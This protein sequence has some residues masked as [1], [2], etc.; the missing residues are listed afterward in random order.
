MRQQLFRAKAH[1]LVLILQHWR[2]LKA[3]SV[4]HCDEAA[5]IQLQA[6]AGVD[7]SGECSS[8][9]T[10]AIN[11][12]QCNF[13][14]A[15]TSCEPSLGQ[16][17]PFA[18]DETGFPNG[19]L[20]CSG[21][22][23]C[24]VADPVSRAFYN[25]K[26][27]NDYISC[28]GTQACRDWR[29]RNLA[30]ACCLDGD[31]NCERAEFSL[32]EGNPS[33]S[34]DIC[35]KGSNVCS[36][37]RI[38][39]ASS[40]SCRGSSVCFR[41]QMNTLKKDLF[42]EGEPT[43]TA[44]SQAVAVFGGGS[45]SHCIRCL[46]NGNATCSSSLFSWE[47]SATACMRCE[48]QACDSAQLLLQNGVNLY[49]HCGAGSCNNL[50]I[51]SIS[52][53]S[54]S[55]SGPGCSDINTTVVN[56]VSCPVVDE[57]LQP[58][59]S[60]PATGEA[61]AFCDRGR[62]AEPDCSA[63]HQGGGFGQCNSVDTEAIN[64]GQ[65]NFDG[66]CTSCEPS[67]G[68]PIPFASDETGFPNGVLNCSGN[69]V[70]QVADPVSRAFYNFKNPNDYISCAGTQACRDWRVRNLAAACCLDGDLN[71]ERA[72]FSL[73]EGNPSC[74][75]DICCKGSNVCSR[76][77][78][79]SASSVSCRG[80]SVCFRAQMNT[81]KKDLFCEGEP[82]GTACSQA[83]AVFG[84][85]SGSHCIRCLGNGNATCS[86]SR[87]SW[88]PSATACMRCETQACDSAQLL[89]QN[90]VN[91][92]LHC[93]AGSCNN[94]RIQS[95]STV[96]CSCSG[97]GCSDINTTV[98]NSVSCPVVDEALQP[99]S[100]CPATGE[101]TAFCDRGRNAEPDC[102]ACHQGGG[103]VTGDPHITALDGR[104][105]TLL[106]EGSFLLWSF[107]GLDAEVIEPEMQKKVPLD[108]RLFAHYSGQASFTKGLLLVDKSGGVA[109]PHEAIELTAKDCRWRSNGVSLST[110]RPNVLDLKDA[111]G[112]L[113][114][115]F[116]IW[117]SEEDPGN[118]AGK[119]S[120]IEHQHVQ[121]LVKTRSNLR[122]LAHLAV[123]CRPGRFLSA[124]LR[125][126]RAEDAR[127]VKGELGPRGH[128]NL[129][130]LLKASALKRGQAS[131]ME[132]DTE[133]AIRSSW[134]ELG[135]SKE[136]AEYLAFVDSQKLALLQ[137]C[138]QEEKEAAALTC[139][140][141]AGGSDQN[142]PKSIAVDELMLDFQRLPLINSRH[143][144]VHPDMFSMVGP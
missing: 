93:G 50:R 41:A 80:S 29:V 141:Q 140:M 118:V 52:T 11:A 63:C 132:L 127:Y 32:V 75:Q 89:L 106:Q 134:I 116:K 82:T 131:L 137:Q 124:R 81:L 136:S 17:I 87:F 99:C 128:S 92:Y 83:V 102:S 20:S 23:V 14:G 9:D 24:Q 1:V 71:C 125:M 123:T 95:I 112:A 55:C 35:C 77:R 86:S 121:L 120:V 90:G 64:A 73:V 76:A 60:C 48:T 8:V 2:V 16:P 111:D 88:E 79:L 85:G 36:R 67:L 59:S 84:G 138:S 47:P 12:G 142:H 25:F 78:I 110:S 4:S 21:N 117:K 68:Q 5:S 143:P 96:S 119:S 10:E 30:A 56:S 53:V 139:K 38:L 57:A 108:F 107:S 58:C 66:A 43:G 18:S 15:C 33:C 97:P 129:P 114:G 31:L 130:N 13:D 51:Q 70:C 62:N 19:V 69:T 103:G 37:A 3:S 98:V 6:N 113:F 122:N 44:C 144:Q 100:S 42:C 74:S 39:S 135:G 49:L 28:A 109:T 46:G 105:Y 72:E 45:G 40:V 115:A 104:H 26:N 34:Q 61:T 7:I 22:T 65:C 91:L 94:L 126:G 133:F 27:P 54:C 101:A